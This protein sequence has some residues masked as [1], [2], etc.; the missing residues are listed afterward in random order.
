MSECRVSV[1]VPACN[2]VPYLPRCLS[3]LQ[4]DAGPDVEIILV[5]DA[6]TDGTPE[7]AES[8]GIE[9]LRLA[10]N[11]G[12][13]PARNSGARRARGTYLMFVDS[14]VAIRPGTLR[15]AIA[16]LDAHPEIA[17]VFGSYDA[18]PEA[19]GVVSEYRNLLH[20]YTHQ[21]GNPEASTFWSGCGA[22]RRQVFLDVGGF[23]EKEYPRSIEDIE[24]G[25]R[26]R[27]AGHRILLDRDMLCTHM[28]RWTL[29]SMVRT[30][31]LGRAIPWT[32]L[33]LRRHAA[34]NDLNIKLGQKLCVVLIALALLFLPLAV[35][36]PFFLAG[37]AAAVLAIVVI[38]GD[39]F[40][41]LARRRGLWFAARSL[42]LHLLYYAYSGMS[43][44]YV[45][46]F[47]ALGLPI[48]DGNSPRP[49]RIPVAG[50]PAQR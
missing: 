8:M 17:A 22:V 12:P 11:G 43:Y 19:K 25:Y 5:D 50:T 16:T 45:R 18:E 35:L 36:N 47:S 26:L 39:M 33:N 40:G 32:R 30:D 48:V 23:D 10:G 4:A 9:V 37:S 44:A 24:L 27:A 13:S 31:V 28:K 1:V 49:A 38:N 14:D 7:L 41:Y 21:N 20:H 3:A 42:P 15:R 6:S 2:A 46:A 34:P 29:G